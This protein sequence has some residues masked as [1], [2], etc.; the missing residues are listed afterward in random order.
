MKNFDARK[1]IRR[2]TGAASAA[3][4]ALMC[5]VCL[6]AGSYP[7]VFY[8]TTGGAPFSD[9]RLSLKTDA[10]VTTLA[11]GSGYE[12]QLM[13]GAVPIKTVDVRIVDNDA[14]I[15]VGD[16]FGIRLKTEGVVVVSVGEDGES[17][18][19]AKAGLM[20][21]DSILEINGKKPMSAKE[22]ARMIENSGGKKL[23]L[24]V[25]RDGKTFETTL[26]PERTEDGKYRSGMWVRDSGAGIGTMTFY[27]PADG[28]YAGLGHAISDF[29]SGKV[30]PISGGEIASAKITGIVKGQSGTP[31]ELVGTILSDT[32]GS[33]EINSECGVYGQLYDRPD[34]EAVKVAMRQ[35]IE[36]GKAY[37]LSTIDENGPQQFEIEILKIDMSEDSGG[38]NL[39]IEVTDPKLLEQTGGI[40][41][42]MS[43]SPILQNGKLIGAVT[44]VF[45]NNPTRGYGLFADTMLAQTEALAK[46]PAA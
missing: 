11:A 19:A 8:V 6:S 35:E 15:A 31:G 4:F 16:A 42:G 37:I 44:H 22:L 5:A 43:G 27:R 7:D 25:L 45:V 13:F 21:G 1:W 34:G 36:T 30:L 2:V 20:P 28:I 12:A 41:Q 46:R 10:V 18:P 14:V 26:I 9:G 40:V 3:V 29:E 17:S 23:K 32:I 38:R 39:I 24:K 33:L